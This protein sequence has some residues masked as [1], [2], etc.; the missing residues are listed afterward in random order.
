[1]TAKT[2]ISV[3]KRPKSWCWPSWDW[4]R[5]PLP[6]GNMIWTTAF[7]RWNSPPTAQSMNLKSMPLPERSKKPTMTG[8]MIGTD[9]TTM[10]T[11]IVTMMTG[12]RVTM[13]TTTIVT[14]MTGTRM[15]TM[16]TTIVTMMTGTRV[17]TMTTTIVTM[18]TGTRMT[19]TKMMITT[20]MMT[21]A[22]LLPQQSPLQNPPQ[23][24]L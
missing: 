17:T 9:M 24:L 20:M 14:M 4:M 22:A 1:M 6:T 7:M 19:T 2:A 10:M 5:P 15:T 13:M 21:T 16:T 3:W 23:S 18:M 8:T 11:T 12:T